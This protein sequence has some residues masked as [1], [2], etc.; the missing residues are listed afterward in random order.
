MTVTPDQKEKAVDLARKGKRASFIA[1]QVGIPVEEAAAIV[2]ETTGRFEKVK[3]SQSIPTNE[4]A[5]A[6]TAQAELPKS[7]TAPR[8][9]DFAPPEPPQEFSLEGDE[10]KTKEKR[11]NP[12]GRTKK[13]EE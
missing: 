9:P 4:F 3:T 7:A 13:D 10:G 8:I 5:A 1:A 2:G 11:P 12:F 6:V